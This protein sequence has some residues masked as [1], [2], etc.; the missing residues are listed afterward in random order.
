MVATGGGEATLFQPIKW[1]GWRRI[2]LAAHPRP[3]TVV[4]IRIRQGAFA[5]NLPHRDLLVSPD[6]AIYVDGK[7]ICARQLVNGT[8][9]RQ[10][11]GRAS[12][13]YFH[14]ELDQH[15]ILLSE[16]LTTESYLDTGN[17]DFFANAGT[18]QA[19]HPDLTGAADHPQRE[20]ASCAPFVWQE[21][22]VKPV[23]HRL[24]QRAATLGHPVPTH[25]STSDPDLRIVAQ[26]RT[27]RP[28]SV[29]NG[30]H[31]FIVPAGTSAVRLLSRAAAPTEAKPW[32]EDRRR[33]GVYVERIVAHTGQDMREVPV[34]HPG[35][36]SGW[37]A[38]ERN[39]NALR[40]WTNGDATLDLPTIDAT[41][42]MLEIR[43]SSSGM[44]YKLEAAGQRRAA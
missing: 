12:V 22:S 33:L 34:D 43:A 20:A 37:W 10:E 11:Q 9:I 14:V 3:D 18:P 17:R 24:A 25:A 27:L 32:I 15:A 36:S 21:D 16:G 38:T 13:D 23:W 31:R 2:N 29:E 42:L 6:H 28:L 1:I 26:G 40:R 19:L 4:P 44:T 30:V 35:L 5:D 7:L 39:G 41:P 8:T